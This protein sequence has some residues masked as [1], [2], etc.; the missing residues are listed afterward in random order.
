VKNI[1]CETPEENW[2]SKYTT[3]KSTDTKPI[4]LPIV[5]KATQKRNQ[6]PKRSRIPRKINSS[7]K[8]NIVIKL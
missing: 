5:G 6:R 2:R 4:K 8:S 3:I 1:D 7:L